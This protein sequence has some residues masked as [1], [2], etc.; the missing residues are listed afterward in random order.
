MYLCEIKKKRKEEKEHGEGTRMG[1]AVW[2]KRRRVWSRMKKQ[3]SKKK[4][5]IIEFESR[6]EKKE[7]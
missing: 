7:R 3:K 1:R 4:T 6:K 2:Q 5:G